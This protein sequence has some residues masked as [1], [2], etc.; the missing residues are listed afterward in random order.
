MIQKIVSSYEIPTARINLVAM[1]NSC[2]L[3]RIRMI[4]S[5]Q[6]NDLNLGLYVVT[7]IYVKIMS[8]SSSLLLNG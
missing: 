5:Y 6:N 7:V 1:K 2:I 4:L 8:M 3:P